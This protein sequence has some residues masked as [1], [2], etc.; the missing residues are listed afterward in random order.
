VDV[1][2]GAIAALGVIYGIARDVA[3]RRERRRRELAEEQLRNEREEREARLAEP[4]IEVR[5]SGYSSEAGGV[6]AIL[7]TVVV[8]NKGQHIARDLTFGLRYRDQ[9][10]VAGPGGTPRPLPILASGDSERWTVR[11]E[12]KLVQQLRASEE[13]IEAVM[14]PWARFSGKLGNQYAVETPPQP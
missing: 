12:P 14:V 7:V 13:R 11:I 9:E 6:G 8:D 4:D 1:V 10:L 5:M 2:F 3:A